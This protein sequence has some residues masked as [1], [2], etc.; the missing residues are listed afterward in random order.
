[1]LGALNGFYGNQLDSRQSELA[2]R[3]EIRRRGMVVEPSAGALAAAFADA[4]SK[5]VVFVH[6]LC[7]TEAAWR[8][9]PPGDQQVDRRS[10][11]ER[12]EEDLGFTPIFLRYNSGLHVSDNGR[13]LAE[14]LDAVFASWPQDVEEIVL[15]GHS[16]G[17]LVARSA[18][19]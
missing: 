7:E 12:L 4:T 2:L 14:L 1:M 19:H 16:M 6:G 9:P 3:M 5:L 17:G 10:Y 18:C 8:I 15:V 13:A 11:G